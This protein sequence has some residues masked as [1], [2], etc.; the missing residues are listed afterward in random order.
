MNEKKFGVD[1]LKK[2]IKFLYGFAIE[3]IE[4]LKDKKLSLPEII[5]FGDNAY[6]GV[7]VF[8]KTPELWNQIK[9]VDTEEGIDIAVFVGELVK[10]ATP[11]QIDEIIVNAIAAIKAEIAIYENNIK[12][13]ISIVK[14]LKK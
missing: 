4:D 3:G 2:A 10:D 7:K 8:S 9:D 6:E 11:D 5:G 14:G 12:P 13:I 1:L